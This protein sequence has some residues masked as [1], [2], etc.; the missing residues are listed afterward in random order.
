MP[1]PEQMDE[2]ARIAS[3]ELAK[4]WKEW[5]AKAVAQWWQKWY[6]PAGH[7]RLG[8]A[9]IQIAGDRHIGGTVLD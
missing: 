9:L 7:K 3:V 6:V 8:R 4:H 2:S 1:T 5:S